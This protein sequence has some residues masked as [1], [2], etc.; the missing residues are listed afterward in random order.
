MY[1]WKEVCI[2]KGKCFADVLQRSEYG[3]EKYVYSF[4]CKVGA[5]AVHDKKE[6]TNG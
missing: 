3:V 2:R 4:M 5:S 1:V 6:S